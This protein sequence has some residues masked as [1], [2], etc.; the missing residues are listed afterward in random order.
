MSA[1]AQNSRWP[2]LLFRQFPL[3]RFQFEQQKGNGRREWTTAVF[4]LRFGLSRCNAYYMIKKKKKP[5]DVHIKHTTKK[6]IYYSC[7]CTQREIR[8]TYAEARE[9]FPKHPRWVLHTRW[10][11]C[12]VALRRRR[13]W[14]RRRKSNW[15]WWWR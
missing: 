8:P 12:D 15:R 3:F 6:E 9:L 5:R 10:R 13:R 7:C 4:L 1:A 2:A 14:R 11:V